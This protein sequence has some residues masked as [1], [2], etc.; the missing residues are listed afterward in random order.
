MS[1]AKDQIG[2]DVAGK[3]GAK[4]IILILDLS[5][6]AV[7]HRGA[8]DNDLT[9]LAAKILGNSGQAD[10]AV[11]WENRNPFFLK[12]SWAGNE[13][14]I[15]RHKWYKWPG[16]RGLVSE[17]FPSLSLLYLVV[18]PNLAPPSDCVFWRGERESN[19]GLK[20]RGEVECTDQYCPRALEANQSECTVITFWIEISDLNLVTCLEWS[21]GAYQRWWWCQSQIWRWWGRCESSN[22]VPLLYFCHTQSPDINL[23]RFSFSL[24]LS[25]GRI[26][27]FRVGLLELTGLETSKS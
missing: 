25:L 16:Q 10:T 26:C 18:S 9:Y 19:V 3:V 13:D 27:E 4:R 7:L 8:R 1:N 22:Q 11:N 14:I 23:S 12:L 21:S 24:F 6:A 17:F 15:H 20:K 2:M 5:P